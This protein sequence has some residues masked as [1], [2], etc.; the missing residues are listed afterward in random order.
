MA[1]D[2]PKRS[3]GSTW[4]IEFDRALKQGAPPYIRQTLVLRTET[5]HAY[6]VQFEV[7]CGLE[8]D[9]ER[10]AGR[11]PEDMARK[12]WE[13]VAAGMEGLAEK[14]NEAIRKDTHERAAESEF[15][16]GRDSGGELPGEGSSQWRR[17]RGGAGPRRWDG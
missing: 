5:R 17:D 8:I 1:P 16:M 4:L 12:V 6:S 7:L 2:G 13:V 9:A 14:I 15:R 10:I 3:Q 11:G